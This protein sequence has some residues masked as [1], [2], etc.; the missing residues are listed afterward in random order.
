MVREQLETKPYKYKPITLTNRHT[1]Y[2][3][4]HINN[5]QRIRTFANGFPEVIDTT[6][7]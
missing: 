2:V 3:Q 5:H 1:R 6:H 4:S 7:L